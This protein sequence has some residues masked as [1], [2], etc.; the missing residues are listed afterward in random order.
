MPTQPRP[1]IRLWDHAGTGLII[2]WPSG[3]EYSNQAAGTSCWQPSVEGVFIPIGNEVGDH[4]ELLGPANALFK[5]FAGPPHYGTGAQTGLTEEDATFVETC[6]HENPSLQNI[7]VD[8]NRLRESCEAWVHVALAEPSGQET[9][10]L[11]EGFGPFP[12]V[13]TWENTD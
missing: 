2:R 9:L 10:R 5:Y 11:F 1:I 3:V 12:L 13:L 4:G 8:R 7:I 6:L